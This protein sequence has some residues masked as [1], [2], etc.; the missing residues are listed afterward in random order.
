[1]TD[2]G[3]NAS[4]L[5]RGFYLVVPPILLGPVL[6]PWYLLWLIPF[7]ALVGPRNPLRM[8]FLYLSGSV[9]LSYLAVDWG[10]LP[11]W[12]TVMELGPVPLLAAWGFWK[13][14]GGGGDEAVSGPGRPAPMSGTP[15]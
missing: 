1:V 11:W 7:L 14:R 9:I 13:T 6:R 12:V 2:D 15:G 5:R 4:I 10:H 8:A 3:S